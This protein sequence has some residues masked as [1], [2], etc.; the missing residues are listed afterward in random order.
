MVW[1][2]GKENWCNLE[3]AYLHFVADLSHLMPSPGSFTTSICTVGVFGTRYVRD[4]DPLPSSL[5]V[6][7]GEV[8]RLS[9]PH[10]YSE[11]EIGTTLAINLRQAASTQHDFVT[12]EEYGNSSDVI[13]EPG[14][15]SVGEYD[16]TLESFNTLS[17]A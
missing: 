16:L 2:Y 15:Q 14:D 7:Q 3:G 4:G 5:E 9:V 10:I 6:A 8:I 17:T 13:I 12:I 11:F 1:P